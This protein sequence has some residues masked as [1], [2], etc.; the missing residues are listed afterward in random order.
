MYRCAMSPGGGEGRWYGAMRES[1]EVGGVAVVSCV[2]L[3]VVNCA[4]VTFAASQ[5]R[6]GTRELLRG[7]S[8]STMSRTAWLAVLLE[9]AS[10]TAG[11]FAVSVK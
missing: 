7:T 9:L 11:G 8:T 10:A 4:R 2:P 6:S 5:C 3:D 1:P